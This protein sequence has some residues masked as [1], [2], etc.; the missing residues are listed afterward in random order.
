[1]NQTSMFTKEQMSGSGQ[2][3]MLDLIQSNEARISELKTTPH[4]FHSDAG[5]GW[6]QVSYQDLIVLDLLSVISGCS[7]RNGDKVYLEEDMDAGSYINAIF[8]DYN[9]RQADEVAKFEYWRDLM[10]TKNMDHSFIRNL[11]HY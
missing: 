6:L 2:T 7:Y 8:G 3:N 1:M 10:T 11:N 9:G 5:H 4:I